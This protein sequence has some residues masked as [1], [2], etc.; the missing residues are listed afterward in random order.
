MKKW[1]LSFI[2]KYLEPNFFLSNTLIPLIVLIIYIYMY[3]VY[4]TAVWSV[5]DGV[6]NFFATK[7]LRYLTLLVVVNLLVYIVIIKFPK[8]K[9]IELKSSIQKFSFGDFFLILLPLTPVVQYIIDNREFLSPMGIWQIA[10]FF[11]LFSII[12]IIAIPTF[13]GFVGASQTMMFLGLAFVFTLT[14]MPSLSNQYAWFGIGKLSTQWKFFGSVF[15]VSWL[16]NEFNS[17][18]TLRFIITVIFFTNSTMHLIVPNNEMDEA[19]VSGNE[20]ISLV[21]DRLPIAIPNVYLLIYDGY[22]TNE[23]MLSYGIDNSSQE[24]F[25][26]AQDFTHYPHTYSVASQSALTMSRVLNASFD[27]YGDVRKGVSGDGVVHNIFSELGYENYGIFSYNMFFRGIESSYDFSYPKRSL[28]YNILLQAILMGEFQF[29]IGYEPK[30]RDAFLDTKQNIFESIG[31]DKVFI[32]M[33]SN[34]PAHSQN[35][36]ACRLNEVDLYEERLD[37]ANIEMQQDIKTIIEYDPLAII[38]VAGDHG[39][40]LT[41]NCIDTG[42]NYDISEISR[43][44]IQDRFGTFLA[45]RWSTGDFGKYDDIA[46]LQDLFPVIFAYLYADETILESKIEPSTVWLTG[47]S[48]A[49]VQSGIIQGG[50]NDGEPLFILDD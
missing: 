23:T 11:I 20:L 21:E 40:Y 2:N 15:L 48:G 47:I 37:L 28:S 5:Q 41:K 42:E 45:I 33:H 13:L 14:S 17:K 49:S 27:F 32:Y 36:G 4:I 34:K 18:N 30:N 31:E 46:I 9:K 10:L 16:L 24:L 44:D 26:E 7:S 19:P 29:D 22:V 3:K 6:N 12:F 25:L 50:I 1:G 8:A 43:L 38:I 39:P 35:S